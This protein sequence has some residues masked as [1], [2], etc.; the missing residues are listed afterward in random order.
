MR[1]RAWRSVGGLRLGVLDGRAG[2]L[3]GYV[4]SPGTT[5]VGA[6]WRA[7]LLL[8]LG[9]P[10]PLPPTAPPAHG[11]RAP[12]FRLGGLASSRSSWSGRAGGLGLALGGGLGGRLPAEFS[13]SLAFPLPLAVLGFSHSLTVLGVRCAHCKVRGGVWFSLPLLPL[14]W[15]P[16]DFMPLPLSWQ[17]AF[18]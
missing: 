17:L 8:R 9:W 11:R 14:N 12:S 3:L 15:Q 1:L 7:L 2:R 6:A 5:P 18:L 13:H 10:G 16:G 4:I